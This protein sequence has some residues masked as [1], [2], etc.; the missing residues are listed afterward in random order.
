[1]KLGTSGKFGHKFENSGNPDETTPYE[2]SHQGFNCL[3]S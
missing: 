2:P 1:M 3:L